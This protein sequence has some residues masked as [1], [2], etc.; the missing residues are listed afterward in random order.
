MPLADG[1]ISKNNGEGLGSCA[2]Q[3]HGDIAAPPDILKRSLRV[4][5]ANG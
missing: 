4:S 1:G 2:R 3:H 5:L